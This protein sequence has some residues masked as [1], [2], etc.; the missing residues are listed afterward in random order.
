MKD[1]ITSARAV[2]SALVLC[3]TLLSPVHGAQSSSH[4]IPNDD[5]LLN[6]INFALTGHDGIRYTFSDRT[7]CVMTH[8]QPS[9]DIMTNSVTPGVQA[10]EIFHINNIDVSRIVFTKMQRKSR[11]AV[12]YFTRV[13]L[14]GESVIRENT[15]EPARGQSLLSNDVTLDLNTTEYDRLVRAWRYIYSHG[16]KSAKSSF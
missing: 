2:L 6:A 7:A 9:F 1:C 12:D 8:A 10:V 5:V 15:F 14:H 4:T 13:E 16:C 3:T 11:D